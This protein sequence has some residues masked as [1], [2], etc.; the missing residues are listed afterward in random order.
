MMMRR[1]PRGAPSCRRSSYHSTREL[2]NG[3]ILDSLD[4][5]F[6]TPLRNG[7]TSP[8]REVDLDG[9]IGLLLSRILFQKLGASVQQCERPLVLVDATDGAPPTLAQ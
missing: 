3:G 7:R 4:T 1:P 6:L 2:A 5:I 8:P 9:Q